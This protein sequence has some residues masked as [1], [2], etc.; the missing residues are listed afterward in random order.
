M[1]CLKPPDSK[2]QP[3]MQR[4]LMLLATPGNSPK[5]VPSHN[6]AGFKS[7]HRDA[8]IGS[9][10]HVQIYSANQDKYL[11]HGARGGRWHHTS[12]ARRLP[13]SIYRVV[14][15]AAATQSH[16]LPRPRPSK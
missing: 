9:C 6:A 13:P 5:L 2:T 1:V 16:S 4:S 8:N 14:E 10:L 15:A 7:V 11:R 3:Y 12:T